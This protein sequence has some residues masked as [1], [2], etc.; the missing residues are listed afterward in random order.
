MPST[1]E[2]TVPKGGL[3]AER[4]APWLAHAFGICLR[5]E[6]RVDGI[7]PEAGPVTKSRPT[8]LELVADSDLD[9]AW[10]AADGAERLREWRFEDGML[11]GSLEHRPDFGYRLSVRGYGTYV[12]SPDGLSIRLA[13]PDGEERWRWQRCL[14]GQ[15]LPLA[16]VLRGVEVFHASAVSLGG[17]ALGL[18]G[19]S[20]S[21]KTSVAV[22]LVLRGAGFLAD[23]VVALRETHDGALAVYPGPGLASV[24]RAEAEAIGD[25]D[26]SRLG[27][28][29]GEDEEALRMLVAR[30]DR[31]R[32]L[33][34]FYFLD[35]GQSGAAAIEALRPADPRLLLANSFSLAVKSPERL[36]RQL[37]LCGRLTE[38]VP[39]FRVR[40]PAA[41]TAAQVAELVDRHAQAVTPGGRQ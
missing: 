16:S 32:P 41:A 20:T 14:V 33:G 12:V 10:G 18:V 38:I 3:A 27:P 37:E 1:T 28:T 21:G 2:P 29:L 7:E 9:L 34:A 30:D 40:I 26:L 15:V 31:P 39:Q 5:G 24:R 35:R 6:L 22:N 23:D 19:A 36:S 17:Y 11:E 4:S 8:A 13:P 25:E